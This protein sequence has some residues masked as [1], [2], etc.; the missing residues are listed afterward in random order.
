MAWSFPL[1]APVTAELRVI[2]VFWESSP[3]WKISLTCC[4][5]LSLVEV[6]PSVCSRLFYLSAVLHCSSQLPWFFCLSSILDLFFLF[7][8]F[9]YF[10]DVS[11]ERIKLGDK[12]STLN[13]KISFVHLHMRKL[14]SRE[15]KEHTH[16]HTHRQNHA[17]SYPVS[18][19]RTKI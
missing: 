8:I 16:I 6:S 18:V 17:Q 1:P 4:K 15:W 12:S 14:K 13:Q 2:L 19:C 9:C 10:S 11:G 7:Y 3:F 5:F